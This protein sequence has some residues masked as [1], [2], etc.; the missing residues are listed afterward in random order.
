MK[1]NVFLALLIILAASAAA[2]AQ[3]VIIGMGPGFFRPYPTYPMY[4]SYPRRRAP[5]QNRYQNLPKF[6]P[7]VIVSVGYGFPNVDRNYLAVFRN[8][9]QGNLS[10]MGPATASVDYRFSRFMSIGAL[11]TH[12]TVKAPYYSYNNAGNSP[13]FTGDISNWAF[14]ANFINYIPVSEKVTPYLRGAIGFNSWK[15]NY[16]DA[17]GSKVIYPDP[18]PDLA[19]QV[20]IGV[21]FDVT[22]H[23]GLFAEAGYGK[24]ILH[25]GLSFKI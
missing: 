17:T 23:A 21:K 10:Q 11:V 8:Y 19:Y 2:D 15:Q 20:S 24:Y 25:A 6:D 13:A 12:G 9:Y 7:Q 16:E 1:K 18:L 3:R 14:M 5:Q 22:K 4:P